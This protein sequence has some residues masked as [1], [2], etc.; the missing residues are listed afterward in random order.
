M[1]IVVDRRCESRGGFTGLSAAYDSERHSQGD[2]TQQ[3]R[4]VSPRHWEFLLEIS[5]KCGY[6][7]ENSAVLQTINEGVCQVWT[8]KQNMFWANLL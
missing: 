4:D 3:N 7:F 5:G 8:G 1:L 2:E 6:P